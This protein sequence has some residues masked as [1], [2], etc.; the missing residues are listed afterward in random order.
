MKVS[1]NN[2][3][4]VFIALIVTMAVVS[5]IGAAMLPTTTTS[6]FSRVGASGAVKANYMAESGYRFIANEYRTAADKD[7]RLEEL[8][9]KSF[10]LNKKKEK[11]KLGIYPYYF[12]TLT[13]P[14]G[15]ATLATK[16]SGGFPPDLEL[17]AGRLKIGPNYYNYTSATHDTKYVTFNMTATLPSVLVGTTVF[18][19]AM[20]DTTTDQVISRG[21]NLILKPGTG[22]PFP[23]KNSMFAM[24]VRNSANVYSFRFYTYKVYNPATSTLIYIGDS[25]NEDVILPANSNVILQKHVIMSSTGVYG[26]GSSGEG[27]QGETG[28][29]E[30]G[31]GETGGGSMA[32]IG[33]TAYSIPLGAIT[34]DTSDPSDSAGGVIET[35]ENF[36]SIDHILVHTGRGWGTYETSD[37]D[38]FSALHVDDVQGSGNN[39]SQEGIIVLNSG[40]FRD[41]WSEVENNYLSYDA[42]VKIKVSDE[43]YYANGISFR[44]DKVGGGNMDYLGVSFI[45]TRKGSG[46]T[47]DGIPDELAQKVNTPMIVLWRL[48]VHGVSKGGGSTNRTIL[49]YKEL[50]SSTGIVDGDGHLVDWSTLRVWVEEK[51]ADS[52]KYAGQ[53]VNDIK[54]YFTNPATYVRGSVYWEESTFTRVTWDS[55]IDDSV[56]SLN[57]N[58]VIRIPDALFLTDLPTWPS[59]RP[60]VGLHSYGKSANAGNVYF[61]DLCIRFPDSKMIVPPAIQ[62]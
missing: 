10:F 51:T 5:A 19:A 38:G 15:T 58:T 44:V 53:R 60:E 54:V 14:V 18:S 41:V 61:D 20:S 31:G 29:G 36:D 34:S 11:F 21:S 32:A 52:G 62:G 56:E 27:G 40:N 47:S 48:D 12:K 42:Q 17:T 46:K 50:N 22:N 3:G 6:T 49:A 28:G 30:T 33:E 59:D 7:A 2:R 39:P 26:S 35:C 16:M 9:S 43:D 13:D 55:D 57:D 8:H 45:R 25:Y 4:S 23:R 37:V 24:L 1:N